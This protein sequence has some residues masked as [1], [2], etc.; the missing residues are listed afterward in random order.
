[1]LRND[2]NVEVVGLLTTISAEYERVSMHATR[3]AILEAQASAAGLSLQVVRL[4]TPCSNEEYERAMGKAV[5]EA[6]KSGIT[7]IAFGDLFLED[8]RAYREQ[9][10]AGSGLEPIFP[11]WSE[12]TASL[13]RRM[14][15][16]GL[17]AIITCVDPRKLQRSFAGRTFD[18]AF[19][20]A[21]PAD[22]DPCGENGEFH[23]CVLSG[24]MFR[25]RIP[26]TVGEVVER[27]GF[28]FADL[29]PAAPASGA[30]ARAGTPPAPRH[31]G[32]PE[33]P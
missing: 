31:L 6:R 27:D 14:V 20:D 10:L 30:P 7:H 13:A 19:L 4:P 9:K 33:R 26:A 3:L 23:T 25:E 17:E 24:P 32:E 15:D 18:H 22:V 8:I 21:L 28:C 1:M 12:P 16:A 11:I 2:P 5:E 29:R